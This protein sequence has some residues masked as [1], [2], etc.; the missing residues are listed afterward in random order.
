MERRFS[1]QKSGDIHTNG[2][3]LDQIFGIADPRVSFRSLPRSTGW[4]RI[5]H[6]LVLFLSLSTVILFSFSSSWFSKYG[7]RAWPKLILLLLPVN[8]QRSSKKNWEQI[9]EMT[10]CQMYYFYGVLVLS[11]LFFTGGANKMFGI[12]VVLRHRTKLPNARKA[13]KLSCSKRNGTFSF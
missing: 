11:P 7:R 8:G 4:P 3:N 12:G 5:S 6:M 9:P 1:C 10:C 2:I 13:C